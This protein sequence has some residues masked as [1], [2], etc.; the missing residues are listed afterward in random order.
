M[1]RS[2]VSEL[3]FF[4][5]VYYDGFLQVRNAQLLEVLLLIVLGFV[6]VVKFFVGKGVVVR[7]QLEIFEIAQGLK[8]LDVVDYIAAGVDILD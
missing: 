4:S 1:R 8:F 2:D 5:P 6:L 7:V 3:L